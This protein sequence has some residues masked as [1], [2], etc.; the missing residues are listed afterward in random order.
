MRLSYLIISCLILYC[1]TYI[2]VSFLS[3]HVLSYP[4]LSHHILS[5]LI[6]AY[7][8]LSC[9]L[10]FH[11][12]LSYL[13]FVSFLFGSVWFVSFG[14]G[15]G[16]VP[17]RFVLWLVWVVCLGWFM[18]VWLVWVVG[19]CSVGGWVLGWFARVGQFLGNVWEVSGEGTHQAHI[20]ERCMPDVEWKGV[21]WVGRWF[22]GLVGWV[23]LAGV[24]EGGC[25]LGGVGGNWP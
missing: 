22:G 25:W 13:V 21:G 2:I 16:G 3:Y 19:R 12:I 18:S 1:L 17:F 9:L 4:I 15:V 8:L 11:L 24:G 10:V 6:I 7:P 23:L 14:L 5:Y 20:R